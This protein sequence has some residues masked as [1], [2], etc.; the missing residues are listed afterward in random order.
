MTAVLVLILLAIAALLGFVAGV[1]K[2]RKQGAGGAQAREAAAYHAGFLAGH[3][4]GWKD[5]KAQGYRTTPRTR[6]QPQIH[7]QAPAAAAP[8]PPAPLR[9]PL[10]FPAPSTQPPSYVPGGAQGRP[11]AL[12]PQPLTVPR[13]SPQE[14]AEAA[15]VRK[16]KR[17][18]QN[19]NITLYVASL[20]LVA[21]GALFLGTS[22]PELLRFVGICCITALFY[23]CGMVIHARVPRLR[24][25]AIAFVGTGLALI[26]V[27]GLAMYNFALHNGPAAWL[28]TSILGTLAYTYA[29]LRLDNKV[30]AFL[31][32]TFVISTAWSG[33]SVLGGA[34]VWYFT[35]LIGMA[36]LLTLMALLS[37][38]WLPPLFLRPVM[39]LH[40]FVVPLV[41]VAVTCMPQ[42]LAKGEYAMVMAMCGIYFAVMVFVPRAKFRLQHF[43]ASRTALTLAVLGLV[44]DVS[45]DATHVMLAAVVCLGVQSVAV[46]FGGNRL[47]PR[48]WWNDA[49]SCLA[50]QVIGSVILM[51]VLALG[52]FDVPASTPLAIT[53]LSA[54]VAG[55]KL[56]HG[57]EFSPA[58]VLGV[59]IPF[60]A[61]LGAWPVSLLLLSAAVY[62]FLRAMVR[63]APFHGY[64]VLA[65]RISLT[66]AVP[67]VVAGLFDGAGDRVAFS[68][69][70]L[71]VAAGIQQVLGAVLVRIGVTTPRPDVS[72]AGFGGVAVVGLL[73]LPVIEAGSGDAV[74][75]AAVI[76][77]VAAAL[78]SGA[79]MFP[80]S[81][82]RGPVRLWRATVAELLAPAM[83]VVAGTVA[84][85]AVSL[86]LANTVVLATIAYLAGMAFR[87]NPSLHRKCYW[88]LA[89]AAG[90]LLAASV[91]IDATRHGLSPRIAGEIP[92]TTLVV[93][94]VAALQLWLP[95]LSNSRRRHPRASVV[96]AGVLVT[97]M[98]AGAIVLTITSIVGERGLRGDWQPGVAAVVTALAAA[99][100]GIFLRDTKQGWVFAPAA[101]V[102]LLAL[103]AGNIRDVEFLLGI[104]AA[105]GCY[106]AASVRHRVARGAYFAGVRVLSSA[107]L[108][109]IV[110][111][112]THSP[113]AVSVTIAVVLI[114]Q[115]AVPWLLRRRLP[116]VPFQRV[117]AWVTL[118]AQLAL[119]FVYLLGRN[120]D[121]GGR[122]VLLFELALVPA[123][124]EV[125][126]RVPGVR[127][128]RYLGVVAVTTAV[129][130]AG[131]ALIFPSVTW[132]SRPL[133]SES[134]VPVVLLLLAVAT[135]V[136]RCIGPSRHSAIVTG[137]GADER[138]LWLIAALTFT[139][140][141]GFLALDV[142]SA[143]TG[144][145]ALV[146]ALVLYAASHLE[147]APS[148]YA[149]AAPFTLVGAVPA[150]EGLTQS[151]PGSVWTAFLPWLVGGAGS[152]A[153][154]Y[155]VRRYG[156]PVILRDPWRRNSLAATAA[157]GLAVTAIVGLV[158]DETAILGTVLVLAAGAL[159]VVEAPYGKWVVAE[160]A[161]LAFVAALQRSLLFVDR[162]VVEWFWIAQW[163]VIAVAVMAGL[164]YNRAQRKEGRLRMCLAAGLLS[165]TSLGTVLGGTA[166]QQLYVLVAHVVLLAA[167][168]LLGERVLVW[169]GAAGTALSIMWALRSYAYAMLALVALALIVLAVWRLNRNP[170]SQLGKANPEA[171]TSDG[172]PARSR[173]GIG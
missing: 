52:S 71:V 85:V 28:V 24:P 13:P 105:Y 103:R 93:V 166:S 86:T 171:P 120:Y 48:I 138:W 2:G 10:L 91:Y 113:A 118:G 117:S 25:A 149:A 110:G 30:L 73:I 139:G 19:I 130:A 42:F 55:W 57:A 12:R 148:L 51:V 35:A 156:A 20:L 114:L 163:Y 161:G 4:A 32:L 78:A 16:A 90:T 143:L 146:L 135:V 26:P 164:R 162:S 67:F 140:V 172:P 7:T 108:A 142:S 94:L 111:D 66:G 151:L 59:T 29:A 3:L 147:G 83:S 64:L 95:L 21:A 157:I 150:V 18:Q 169:W 5:A 109:V 121:D 41:A 137:A 54:M 153:G 155:A 128:T 11:S 34:L 89:R 101:L 99:T 15:A 40:P 133:L 104:F 36:I 81:R 61:L 119:P 84:L 9:Q 136:A 92:S 50:L 115:P 132:L 134:L 44:W 47:V 98:A 124:A 63:Q 106:M 96:D 116:D 144:L 60:V 70:G 56:G 6:I 159:V 158:H 87:I 1:G 112:L 125:A 46:A 167:G 8:A 79:L 31:S 17:D 88:W 68:L 107:L 33:V 145:A 170:S 45:S 102:L 72:A 39:T 43:Y 53:M 37:P 97:V 65:G 69:L 74:V 152:A 154:M 129:V 127:G 122:W 131:P 77:V 165:L 126:R 80:Y 168:L 27:T 49:I 62:W 14:S 76:A 141:G 173:E 123:A 58:A 160:V 100:A 75:T 22:L 38:R 23:V 82:D